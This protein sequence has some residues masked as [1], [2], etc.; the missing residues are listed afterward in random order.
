MA[1]SR[2]RGSRSTARAPAPIAANWI[3]LA[4]WFA[5]ARHHPPAR[6]RPRGSRRQAAATRRWTGAYASDDWWSEPS[7]ILLVQKND[8]SGEPPQERR[9]PCGHDRVH[10][11]RFA[12]I[13]RDFRQDVE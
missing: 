4:R 6:S 8:E 13:L 2:P 10:E 3:P 5:R 7:T 12:Q 1:R 9:Q 11:L